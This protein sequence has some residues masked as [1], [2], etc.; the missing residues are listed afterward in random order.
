MWRAD[1][2]EKPLMLGKIEGRRRRGQQGWDGWMASPTQWTWVW[3]NFGSWWWIGRPGVLQFMGSQRVRHDWA[4]ELNWTENIYSPAFSNIFLI[5]LPLPQ[6]V[7]LRSSILPC[8]IDIQS[9]VFYICYNTKPSSSIKFWFFNVF[10]INKPSQT[11]TGLNSNHLV[12]G[13]ILWVRCFV[14][15]DWDDSSLFREV[16][17]HLKLFTWL[18]MAGMAWPG[19]V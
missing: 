16:W 18:K 19:H 14:K 15:A 10:L 17:A 9:H 3:I 1:S 4:T 12:Y 6:L 5:F 8:N 7:Y 2:L 13:V 11:I